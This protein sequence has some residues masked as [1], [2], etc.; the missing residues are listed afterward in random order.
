[1]TRKLVLT[2]LALA[3]AFAG[4]TAALAATTAPTTDPGVTPTSILLGG[5][6]PLTGPQTPYASI[7]RG[8]KA[9]FDYVN[10]HGGVNGRRIEYTARDDASDPVRTVAETRRLVEQDGVFAIFN[11]FGT[12]QTDLQMTEVSVVRRIAAAGFPV[13]T[14]GNPGVFPC[15]TDPDPLADPPVDGEACSTARRSAVRWARRRPRRATRACRR[16]PRN[17]GGRDQRRPRPF[18]PRRR[19]R[20]LT[21]DP[22]PRA[23]SGAARHLIT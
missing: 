22:A 9:Y 5:T 8:A 12:E 21:P 23:E 18:L 1:M 15:T 10:S 6:A 13:R 20:W 17:R 7:A 14:Q 2:L 16:G 11:S 3:L 4:A 19:A